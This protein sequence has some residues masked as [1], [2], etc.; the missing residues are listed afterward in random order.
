[1]AELIEMLFGMWTEVGPRNHVL[2]D[3]PD[4]HAKG[5]FEGKWRPIVK[6]RD[7]AVSCAKIAEL[8]EMPFGVWTLV[9]PRKHQLG[10]HRRH[11]SNMIQPSICGGDAAFLSDHFD[12][13]LLLINCLTFATG[14]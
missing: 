10:S 12:H 14:L 4:P 13:L 6:Y 1:M 11:L 8:I 9:G 3:G 5:S 7:S 2:D